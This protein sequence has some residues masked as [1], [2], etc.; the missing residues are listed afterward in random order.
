VLEQ[1]GQ[2][3]I[4]NPTPAHLCSLQKRAETITSLTQYFSHKVYSDTPFHELVR[5][6]EVFLAENR[7]MTW[8]QWS[9]Y[10]AEGFTPPKLSVRSGDKKLGYWP[11]ASILAAPYRTASEDS[12]DTIFRV[13]HMRWAWRHQLL[14]GSSYPLYLQTHFDICP[15]Y[16]EIET[17]RRWQGVQVKLGEELASWLTSHGQNT[18]TYTFNGELLD[19]LDSAYSDPAE[20][21]DELHAL[22]EPLFGWNDLPALNLLTAHP[23]FIKIVPDLHP[24]SILALRTAEYLAHSSDLL[25]DCSAAVIEYC[26]AVEIELKEKLLQPLQARHVLPPT[27]VKPTAPKELDKLYNF[28]FSSR[29]RP[30][31]LGTLAVTVKNALRPRYDEDVV[32]IWLRESLQ[33]FPS[34]TG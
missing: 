28:V 33:R 21:A 32:A 24:D 12:D 8:T 29:T 30:L 1:C 15:N 16:I 23:D 3:G 5:L 25:P 4:P 17:H 7:Y 31:E 19:L 18:Y 34:S 6:L 10:R 13:R 9:N 14:A 11:E 22:V 2:A 26:K 27:V 20:K